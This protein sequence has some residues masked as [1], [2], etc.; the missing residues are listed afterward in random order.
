MSFWQRAKFWLE[1]AL[2][3]L[4]PLTVCACL[5]LLTLAAV[6]VDMDRMAH[7]EASALTAQAATETASLNAMADAHSKRMLALEAQA[8]QTLGTL[9]ATLE[10]VNR[11][12]GAMKP[13]GTL[14]D[15]AKTL[16]AYRRT[17]A[18]VNVAMRH[19]DRQL[20]TVDT[21]L[22]RL[23]DSGDV[24]IAKLNLLLD[25]ANQSV[26]GLQPVEKQA[27][28]LI[29]EAQPAAGK[30]PSIAKHVD[31]MTS[32]G[33]KMLADAQ[34]KEHQLLHPT[35]KKLTFWGA[36]DGGVLWFHSHLMPSIF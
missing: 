24:A 35:K 4:T 21:R 27:T 19:E 11:N 36:I 30:L 17:G 6:A 13:C 20:T 8:A 14:A 28:E 26:A 31:G 34:W 12:C 7:R 15:V 25:T 16:E 22:G 32:S 18:L 3:R 33:D 5:L 2:W 1:D 23:F 10:H 29:A 9:N